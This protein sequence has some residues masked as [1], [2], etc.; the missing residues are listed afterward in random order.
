MMSHYVMKS[1]RTLFI[2]ILIATLVISMAPAQAAH[3]QTTTTSDLAVSLI[4]IPKHAKA[5]QTLEATYTVTNLGPD[6]AA[7]LYLQVSI[8]DAYEEMDI[9][10][11]PESLAVGETA[12][13]SAVIKVLLFEPGEIRSAW[14]G[15]T[16]LSSSALEPSID[17]DVDNSTTRTPMRIIG[18]HVSRC[19]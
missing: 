14:V 12:T 19:P 15:V 5:C 13:V 11:L 8:P 17:P 2:V 18:K 1:V 6:P 16:L 4:S 3:A 10:G 9:V 7:H